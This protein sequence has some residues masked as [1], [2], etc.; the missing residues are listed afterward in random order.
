MIYANVNIKN[1]MWRSRTDKWNV[2]TI[3]QGG[4]ITAYLPDIQDGNAHEWV[5]SL[6]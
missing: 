6:K 4:V 5:L 3:S 2:Y 1:K